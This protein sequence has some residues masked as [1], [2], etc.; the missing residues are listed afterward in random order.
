[1][2]TQRKPVAIVQGAPSA[3]V[4][5]LFREFVARKAR[6]LRI[7]G[8]VE[9][10]NCQTPADGRLL[11]IA[12]GR[13]FALFQELGGGSVACSLDAASVVDASSLVCADIA[14]GCD[15]VVLNKFGKLEAENRS[16]LIPAF[17]AAIEAGIPILTSVS[18]KFAEAWTAF[19]APLFEVLPPD[20]AAIE[21]WWEGCGADGSVM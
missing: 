12:D 1:M 21:A 2:E 3:E 15:L 17:A 8:L 9:S 7:A 4:Q 13:S 19:A 18:P 20:L 14:R 6:A 5:A 16:G 11:S 10:G